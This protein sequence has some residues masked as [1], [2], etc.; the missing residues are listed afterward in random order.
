[1][2]VVFGLMLAAYAWLA[3]A[4]PRVLAGDLRSVRIGSLAA[5]SVFYGPA[6]PILALVLAAWHAGQP[7][8]FPTE[9][10]SPAPEAVP[11]PIPAIF[12]GDFHLPIRDYPEYARHLRRTATIAPDI[13]YSP[14]AMYTTLACLGGPTPVANPQHRLRVAH[15]PTPLLILNARHDPATAYQWAVNGTR[16]LGHSAVLLTYDGW[17]HGA[18]GRTPCTTDAVDL[19]LI[20]RT[21]PASGSH[22]PAADD[23]ATGRLATSAQHTWPSLAGSLWRPDGRASAAPARR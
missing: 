12:C 3:L 23:L 22:C 13:R 18:Y 8:P 5:Q 16:Q 20:T 2:S 17:G 1:M 4:A 7:Y 19:H 14:I 11:Y 21:P 6:W 15:L 10:P 9:P